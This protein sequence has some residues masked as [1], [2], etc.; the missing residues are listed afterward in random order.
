MYQITSEQIN[1]INRLSRQIAGIGAMLETSF[2]DPTGNAQSFINDDALRSI[3]LL[4]NESGASIGD[5]LV[6]VETGSC[7]KDVD[8][9]D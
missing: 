9:Q 2:S 4:L 5:E 3:G 6:K 7:L 8:T 1:Q